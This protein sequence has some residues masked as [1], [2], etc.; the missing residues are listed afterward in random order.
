LRAP[1][2]TAIAL[3]ALAA[4]A[5]ARTIE[6][7]GYTWDVRP[8]RFGSPG[9][10]QWSDSPANASVDSSGDLVLSNAQGASVELINQARLGYGTYRW[11]V[12]TNLSTLDADEVLGMFT[13]GGPPPSNNEI[14]IEP[15]HWGRLSR[16]TGSA[17]VWQ[18]A[19]AGV[20]ETRDF[21]YSPTPPYL[22]QF[23][24]APGKVT[25]RISDG[26]GATLLDWVVTG[27]VPTPST[28][29]VRINYWRFKGRPAAGTRS[30]RLAS[31]RWLPLGT[32]GTPGAIPLSGLRLR[33]RRVVKG[34]SAILT[35]RA[36]EAATLRVTV[37]RGS[38]KVRSITRHVRAGSGRLRL[39]SRRLRLGVYRLAISDAPAVAGAATCDRRSLRLRV[40][41]R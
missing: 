33:S 16:R 4:P 25:Y 21:A 3:L 26:A 37:L 18:D 20:S 1:L 22:N 24:W 14:D 31:F 5:S 9:P 15:S 27:G 7:S 11:M 29:S 23:T 8:P 10:N 19:R 2:L 34:R 13:Y 39:S 40:V 30:V 36:S 6:W 32:C 35:W 12:A 41:R 28:E 17:T 38:T